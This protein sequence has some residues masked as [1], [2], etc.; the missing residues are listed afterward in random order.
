MQFYDF[1]RKPYIYC[2]LCRLDFTV[3]MIS[4]Y[5]Y[6]LWSILKVLRRTANKFKNENLALNLLKLKI[7]CPNQE[8]LFTIKNYIINVLIQNFH[9]CQQKFFSLSLV[10]LHCLTLNSITEKNLVLL[11][12]NIIIGGLE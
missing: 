6:K 7:D 11:P 5:L 1:S 10:H 4:T 2:W 8:T 12:K 3:L 9:V